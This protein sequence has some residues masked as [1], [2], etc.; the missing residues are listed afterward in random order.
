ME[1]RWGGTEKRDVEEQRKEVG[2]NRERRWIGTEKGGM[3]YR[4]EGFKQRRLAG[5]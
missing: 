5:T 3:K 4:K 2:W 1:L